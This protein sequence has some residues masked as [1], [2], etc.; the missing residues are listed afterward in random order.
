MSELLGRRGFLAGSAALAAAT[1]GGT[2]LGCSRG[3]PAST[4]RA[5]AQAPRHGG[6][7]R[8]GIIDYDP[9]GGLDVHKPSGTGSVIR[10]F[11]LYSKLWEWSEEMLPRLALAEF[12][13]PNADASSWTIRLKKGLEFH[14]GKTITADDVIFSVR[15]LT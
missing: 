15:R 10:G 5:S 2:L 14:H 4:P 1:A 9:A 8:F 11:A 6:R 13:E 7:I 12:A 3:E